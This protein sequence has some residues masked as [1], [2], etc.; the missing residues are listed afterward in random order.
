MRVDM[1]S[2]FVLAQEWLKETI[3]VVGAPH[4]LV[5][6]AAWPLSIGGHV[7]SEDASDSSDADSSD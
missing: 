1:L 6:L 4:G 7:D 2:D 3:K 5:D